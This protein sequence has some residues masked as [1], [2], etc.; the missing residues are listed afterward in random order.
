ML[1]FIS[2]LF[3]PYTIVDTSK[4]AMMDEFFIFN[5]LKEKA[6]ETVNSSRNCED[7][8]FNL[9]EY[10]QFV[11]DYVFEK[12]KLILEFSYPSP[13]CDE[14]V[15]EKYGDV[16]KDIPPGTPAVVEF[17]MTLLSPNIKISD[18]FYGS[19]VPSG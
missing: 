10:T 5:N 19:W 17:N 14:T 9:E 16:C 15:Y 13:C 11:R 7:L 8:E 3:E 4:V 2:R 1:F 18:I 6:I 12:G